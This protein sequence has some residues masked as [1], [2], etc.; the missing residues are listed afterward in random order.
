MRVV[1]PTDLDNSNQ[2]RLHHQHTFREHGHVVR[3]FRNLNRDIKLTCTTIPLYM[4]N[5]FSKSDQY[6]H[7]IVRQAA[8]NL[9]SGPSRVWWEAP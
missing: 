6:A 3:Q 4:Y 7:E 8:R 2:G 5:Q 9:A 1:G